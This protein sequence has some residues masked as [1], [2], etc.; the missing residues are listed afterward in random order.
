MVNISP[1]L[2]RFDLEDVFIN[3]RHNNFK[4]PQLVLKSQLDRSRGM[5]YNAGVSSQMPIWHHELMIHVKDKS[6][7]LVSLPLSMFPAYD[8]FSKPVVVGEAG[9][10]RFYPCCQI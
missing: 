9:P 1:I 3:Q 4:D 5:P 2:R 10:G 8:S 6:D 7:E